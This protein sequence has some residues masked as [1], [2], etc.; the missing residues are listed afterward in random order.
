MTSI[1]QNLDSARDHVEHAVREAGPVLK[2][3][4]R[5]GFASKGLV[6]V[7]VGVLAT[8]AAF[9][10]GGS[11]TDQQ[12]AL[13]TILHQPFGR[14][15]LAIAGVGLVGYAIWRLIQA[16]LDPEHEHGTSP[17]ELGRR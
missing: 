17:K 12:G 9:N 5:L 2:A 7:I 14:T 1:P 16:L 8:Q 4:A 11:T 15:M 10:T 6:Y 13:R 3:L